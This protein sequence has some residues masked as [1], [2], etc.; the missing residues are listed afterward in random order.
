MNLHKYSEAIKIIDLYVNNFESKIQESMLYIKALALSRLGENENSIKAFNE[1][2]KKFPNSPKRNEAIYQIGLVQISMSRFKDAIKTFEQISSENVNPE[3][4]EKA[5]YRI[6]ECYFNQANIT[7]AG[8]A[9]NK[10]IK[11]FPQGKT[12]ID[13][14]YQLGELAYMQNSYADAITAFEAIAAGKNELSSQALFRCG[15][16]LMKAG[17]YKEAIKKFNEYREKDPKGKL[18]EDALFKKGLC[19][20]E[21]KDDAQALAAFSQLMNAQGYFRQEAR[22]N[23]AEIARKVDNY[24]LAI[25]HYKA[26]ISEEPKHPLAVVS[27]ESVG[28]CLY[29]MKDYDGAK[30]TFSQILKDYPATDQVVPETRLWL[31]RTMIAME[32]TENGIL[33]LL[34]VPVLYPR[35]EH[36]ATAYTEAARAYNKLNKPDKAKKMYS[37]VLKSKPSLE[38]KKEAE[39]ATKKKAEEVKKKKTDESK[40]KKK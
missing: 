3:I 5:I 10:V 22:F 12:R 34:K 9:F 6:G 11:I 13:A 37:E 18:T 40:K 20:Q 31:G 28:I 24:P 32:D 14:L 8:N 15:E 33:E 27:K 1:F 19:Y 38:Q 36:I 2:M 35:S 29:A 17:D 30:E 23:I 7:E 16:I 26:I 39:E 25:Q 21:L 4:R